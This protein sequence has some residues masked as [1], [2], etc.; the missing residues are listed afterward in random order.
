M[1]A[2]LD[3]FEDVKVMFYEDLKSDKLAFIEELSKFLCLSKFNYNLD[4]VANRTVIPKNG[5]IARAFY[6]KN[7][8]SLNF[9]P[10]WLVRILKKMFFKTETSNLNLELK[11]KYNRIFIEDI[12][13]LESLLGKDLSSW[14]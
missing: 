14:K 2:Y 7:K 4:E 13:R 3:N 10:K 5:L 12:T 11:K 1:K 8:Y 6:Y 9:I